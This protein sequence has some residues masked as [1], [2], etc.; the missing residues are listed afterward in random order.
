MKNKS[1]SVRPQFV[2]GLFLTLLGFGAGGCGGKPD[3]PQLGVTQ[4][5]VTE[6]LGPELTQ[7]GDII[8]KVTHPN[9]GGS[10]HLE[11]IRDGVTPPVGSTGPS[12]QYDTY[13]SN[14]VP[15]AKTDDWVGYQYGGP[16]TFSR[17]VFQEGMNF[18]DGGWFTTLRVQVRQGANWVTVPGMAATPAYRP[19]AAAGAGAGFDTYRL[20]F[21]PVT[22]T[23]IRIEGPPGG[24]S[25]F[26]SVAELRVWAAPGTSGPPPAPTLGPD[27]TALAKKP[28]AMPADPVELTPGGTH[29]LQTIREAKSMA[30]CDPAL[31]DQSQ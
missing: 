31:Q 16:V 19:G 24:S 7:Q 14:A 13:D 20:D 23:G 2:A 17:V 30:S 6:G 15:S 9:G 26:I 25:Q 18:P 12:L 22:G 29:Y 11:T 21:P 10:C 5:A 4:A 27:L 1:V 3:A 28:L 8:A